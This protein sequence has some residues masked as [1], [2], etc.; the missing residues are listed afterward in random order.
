MV[1]FLLWLRELKLIV[2]VVAVLVVVEE[3]EFGD[4]LIMTPAPPPPFDDP[5]IKELG[6]LLLLVDLVEPI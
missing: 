4:E 3:E 5:K 6:L 2:E 1:T